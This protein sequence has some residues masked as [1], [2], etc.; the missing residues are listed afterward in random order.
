NDTDRK[1]HP[2]TN[3]L[4]TGPHISKIE[5]LSAQS[6]PHRL[7]RRSR[8]RGLSIRAQRIGGEPLNLRRS[9]V[10][11]NECGTGKQHRGSRG[12]EPENNRIPSVEGEDGCS[13]VCQANL[14]DC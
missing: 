6:S 2:T 14:R 7:S 3:T 9:H 4:P 11:G 1:Q 8:N 13:E 12:V 5:L 10:P